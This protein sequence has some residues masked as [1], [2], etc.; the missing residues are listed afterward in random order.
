M[1]VPN[2]STFSL[3]DVLPEITGETGDLADCFT[4]AIAGYFDPTYVGSKNSLLNF[5]NYGQDNLSIFLINIK[6][7]PFYSMA[8]PPTEKLNKFILIYITGVDYDDSSPLN[9]TKWIKWQSDNSDLFSLG[10]SN[11][12][13]VNTQRPKEMAVTASDLGT[14]MSA[15]GLYF[16]LTT[17]GPFAK[18]MNSNILVESG[19]IRMNFNLVTSGTVPTVASNRSALEFDG[20]RVAITYN[21]FTITTTDEWYILCPTWISLT[22]YYGSGNTTITIT[23]DTNDHAVENISIYTMSNIAPAITTILC[24]ATGY[25]RDWLGYIIWSYDYQ[26]GSTLYFVAYNGSTIND[27]SSTM[28]W[29]V[30]DG[31]GSVVD[32]GT[33]YSGVLDEY[34]DSYPTDSVTGTWA[35]I[36]GRV[37]GGS[38]INI[39]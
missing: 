32:A 35:S 4:H 16:Y 36:W 39:T 18:G 2:T 12:A 31:G 19:R 28:E 27:Q 22:A 15:G 33:V 1:A 17:N 3:Q 30:R 38:W 6:T 10:A 24:Y 25:S 14:L 26:S 8:S 13:F 11:L 29:Q 23:V 37:S 5:R 9:I 7:R 21:T 20:D 34:Q